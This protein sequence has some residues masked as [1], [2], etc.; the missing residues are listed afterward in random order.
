MREV[1][2]TVRSVASAPVS[3]RLALHGVSKCYEVDGRLLP[4]L[5]QISLDVAD[6]EF[7]A[8]VG[9]S[10]CGKSTLLRLI[11]GLDADFEGKLSL[12]DKPVR[13]PGLERG[14]VFQDHRLLPWL[15]VEA[16]VGLALTAYALPAAERA[17][18]VTEVLE[19]VGLDHFAG[20]YPHQLSGGMAQ[21]AA[22]ARGLVSQPSL[23]LMDEPFGA[24]D[25]LTRVYLQEELLRI[26][27][28]RRV[29]VV[30]VTHD[31]EEAVF[32]A[33]TVVVLEP[34]PGRIAARLSIQ[35]ER[36]RD[37]TDPRF[38]AYK[39]DILRRLRR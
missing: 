38:V 29:T 39:A 32:L 4:V 36:P 1:L 31:V 13:G 35:M 27:E 24:L 15:T 8:V 26:W 30:V 12:D 34:D 17:R 3:A 10:G 23:L 20:A 28:R 11:A 7:V 22:I 19:L 33:D 5:E 2:E 14:I 25:S 9:A 21:R 18:R 16:N 37:R 6:G